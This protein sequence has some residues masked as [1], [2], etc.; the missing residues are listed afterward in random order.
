MGGGG[1]H[2]VSEGSHQIVMSFSP[3]VIGCLL[4]K[5]YKRGSHGH[6]MTPLATPPR[7]L[8]PEFWCEH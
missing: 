8:S 1:S 4:K 2:C 3:A 6:R 7:Y 5:P